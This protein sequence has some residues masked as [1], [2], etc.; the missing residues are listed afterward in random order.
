MASST[1]AV[2]VGVLSALCAVMFIF[3]WWWFPRHYQ[4]GVQM[5]M[6]RVVAERQARELAMQQAGGVTRDE[7]A[8]VDT[9]PP[10]ENQA[11][12]V[13]TDTSPPAATTLT[14]HPPAYTSY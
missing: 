4:K 12:T 7:E 8:G 13:T 6:D 14:Y 9:A 5:D 2:P 10:Y 11:A 1:W 3:I